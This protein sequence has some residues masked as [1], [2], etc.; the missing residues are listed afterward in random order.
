LAAAFATFSE[1]PILAL[2]TLLLAAV[3]DVL[4]GYWARRFGQATATGAV[5]DG[6]LDKLFAAVVV[7]VLV[8]RGQ[9][10]PLGACLLATRE[11]GELPLVV[12]WAVHDGKRH[13]RA[14]DPRANWLGKAATVV[15]F[16]AIA[17]VL[18]TRQT[19]WAWLVL[20]AG[21]GVAS[22]AMYWK[23]ELTVVGAR[24]ESSA[25]GAVSAA[26]EGRAPV[27]AGSSV[28]RRSEESSSTP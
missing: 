5:V 7:S 17:D 25:S 20:S 1:Q 19:P 14:Q 3:T 11:L 2:G 24:D 16:V 22:A 28:I 27:R 13:A 21:T 15:Q 8:L 4:D 6:V 26:P 10:P 23:R 12:W 18:L 9:L